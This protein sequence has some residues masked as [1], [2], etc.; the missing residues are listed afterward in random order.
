MFYSALTHS[1][2]GIF[3]VGEM[4]VLLLLLCL[5][6]SL[7]HIINSFS[8]RKID[9]IVGKSNTLAHIQEKYGLGL[10]VLVVIAS[11]VMTFLIYIERP[12]VLLLFYLAIAIAAFY[13]LPPIRLKERGIFG[14]ISAA[15]AQRTL[16]VAIVFQAM[17]AWNWTALIICILGTLTGIRYIIV[18]QIKDESADLRACVRTVATTRGVAFLRRL[19]R[20]IVFP[21]ELV[22]LVVALFLMSMELQPVG[23]AAVIYIFWSVLQLLVLDRNNETRFSVESYIILADFYYFYWPLLLSAL[24]IG[25]DNVFWAVFLFTLVWLFRRL[26]REIVQV[27]RV[28]NTLR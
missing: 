14:L 17:D 4:A 27:W 26:R 25:R 20:Q 8:D 9:L 11:L 22:T 10:V 12:A 5:Y 16:P 19:L 7:G 15:I 23:V 18:H 3:L 1:S 6:A 28:F 13:S 24:L 21:L 2:P